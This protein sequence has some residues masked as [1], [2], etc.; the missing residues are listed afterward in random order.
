MS[1]EQEKNQSPKVSNGEGRCPVSHG[2]NEQHTNS[3][4]STRSGIIGG[5]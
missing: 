4:R 3:A 5:V 2:S 1:M